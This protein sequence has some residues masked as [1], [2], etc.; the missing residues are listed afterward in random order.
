VIDGERSRELRRSVLRPQLRIDDPLP[1]DDRD[2]VI[3]F[4][5]VAADGEVLS[6][7]RIFIEACPWR[8]EAV[9]G[10]QLRSMATRPD[11]R[12]QGLAG[13]ILAAVV[14]HIAGHGGG[15]LWCHARELAVPMYE[16]G[17]LVIEGEPFLEH[18]IP[19]RSMW[20][21]IAAASTR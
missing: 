19:H 14:D 2:D 8:A 4:G 9:T 6:T 18:G 11:A 7:C 17:G 5:A 20:R 10:W 16:R 3:T 12:G 1:G 21:S 13:R 15:I